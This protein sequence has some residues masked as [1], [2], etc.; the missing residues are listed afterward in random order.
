MALALSRK[1]NEDVNRRID[2]LSPED[3]TAEDL[4]IRGGSLLGRPVTFEGGP[5]LSHQKALSYFEQALAKAPD[6]TFAKIGIACV[7]VRNVWNG[8]NTS[9]EEAFVRAERLLA[10]VLRVNGQSAVAHNL[11]GILRLLQGRLSDS[12]I[13]H[14]LATELEP[15]HS[16]MPT[17][18]GVTLAFLGQPTEAI[19]L[20]ERGLRLDPHGF[21][22][23]IS[24]GS[25][26]LCH[27]LLGNAEEAV[28]SLRT[29]RAMNPRTYFFH[30]LLAA[31]LGLKG[32]LDEA[33]STFRKAIEM[34]SDLVAQVRGSLM[35]A[36]PEY[37]T[38]YEKSVYVGLRR[39]GLPDIWFGTNERPLGWIGRGHS[40]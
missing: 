2:A 17:D 9:V 13:E 1:I 6:S 8:E 12:L 33:S 35:R 20:I 23:S 37:I 38:L 4:V 15:N 21:Y 36:C 7:L 27:L 40:L 28:I 19:P 22:A 31:A 3:W 25:L 24:H 34:K 10:D 30:W 29:A 16:Y 11:M 5:D 26:G 32:D 14:R 18:L 39:A